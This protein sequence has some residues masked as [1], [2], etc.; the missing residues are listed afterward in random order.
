MDGAQLVFVE[1]KTRVRMQQ[2]AE[3]ISSSKIYFLEAAAEAY[4]NKIGFVGEARFD[5]IL[6][7]AGGQSFE[8][9]HIKS[10]FR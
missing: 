2:P 10:A 5:L 3:L 1:V 8:L 6:L 4:I 7:V 9:E